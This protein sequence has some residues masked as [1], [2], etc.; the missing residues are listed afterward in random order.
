MRYIHKN[1]ELEIIDGT[2]LGSV[3]VDGKMTFRGHAYL[4]IKEFIRLSGNAPGVIKRFK[5]QLDMREKPKFSDLQKK[6][7]DYEAKLPT[8]KEE[9]KMTLSETPRIAKKEK[10]KD[11]FK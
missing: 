2:G 11:P 1:L 6:Q 9:F 7:D 5:S 10:W 4:A 8:K 3:V